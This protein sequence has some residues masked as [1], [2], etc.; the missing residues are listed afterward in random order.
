MATV[1]EKILEIKMKIEGA[2]SVKELKQVIEELTPEMASLDTT[3]EEY[4]QTV[5]LMV[6]AQEKLT[7]AMK[8]GKSQIDAQEGSYNALVNKMA[9]L[10]KVQKAVTDDESRQRLAV[11]INAIND[12]LKAYDQA[13]GVYVRNVGNYKSALEGFDGVVVSFGDR[14]KEAMDTLEPTKQKFE[15]VQKIA[16]GVASGFAALQGV[17]ALLGIENENLEKSLVKVQAA[18]AIAQGIGGL[19]DLYEGIARWGVAFSD[20]AKAAEN[21]SGVVETVN[22][23]TEAAA[24]ASNMAAAAS[25]ASASASAADATAKGTQAVATEGATIAQKGLNT[26][27]KANPIGIVITA[28]AALVG[29]FAWLKDDIV[30]LLGGTEKM[31][32]AWNNFSIVFSG[33]GNVIKQVALGPVKMLIAE[34]RTLVEVVSSV[35]QGDFKGAWEA[36]KKGF[37]DVVDA[38]KDTYNVIGNYQEAAA[39]KSAEIADKQRREEAEKRVKELE[40][41]IKDMEAKSDKDWKYSEEGKKAYEELYKRRAEMYKK[42]S[43]EYKQNQRDIWLYNKDYQ[44]RITKKEEEENKKRIEASKKAI[45]EVK[46]AREK[47][48]Q[49]YQTYVD[50]YLKSD[51]DKLLE[52]QEKRRKALKNAYDKG[53]IDY[54]TYV[55]QG[56][57]LLTKLGIEEQTFDFNIQLT[58]FEKKIKDV[59]A[60]VKNREFIFKTKVELDGET[61][62]VES[63]FGQ[64]GLDAATRYSEEFVDKVNKEIEGALEG[65]DYTRAL[66]AQAAHIITSY[67]NQ[68]EAVTEALR[69]AQ[70]RF[71]QFKEQYGEDNEL[72][73]KADKEVIKYFNERYNLE[74]EKFKKISDL[75]VSHLEKQIE[76][77]EKALEST[78]LIEDNKYTK[79][80]QTY[81]GLIDFEN[82][83]ITQTKL[84]RE[85]EKSISDARIATWKAEVEQYQKAATDMNITAEERVKAEEKKA[86][87]LARIKQEELQRDNIQTQLKIE[88]THNYINAIQDSLNGISDILGNVA[89]AWESSIQAQVDAGEISEEEGERQMEN[90]RGIQSAIALINTFSSA[91]SAYQ[92]LAPIPFV[93]PV[94]GAAAAAAAIA[95][96]LMQVKAINAVKKGDKG[97]EST[98]YAEVKPTIPNDYSPQMVQNATGGSEKEDLANALSQTNLWISV[99][100]IDSAQNRVKTRDKESSF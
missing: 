51:R 26:A 53:L 34:I 50:T 49:D 55:K 85:V 41:Y 78:I 18:M 17:T 27:M 5:D 37:E 48:L 58:D 70:Y 6:K 95:S 98:R 88:N 86:E 56:Q 7:T 94:L 52:E 47:A 66:E 38:A 90:M 81:N 80:M 59:E 76:D 23:A 99:K 57:E 91:V 54:E 61:K 31:N 25:A 33:V 9:A 87:I 20:T 84:L 42:D 36:I 97:G 40:D 19:K 16:T 35:A 62:G 60:F 64:L 63:Y 74:V 77:E 1:D 83:Y 71:D 22:N 21:M 10:K 72:T 75:R 12:Q 32:V 89:S 11:E 3:S 4:S 69:V 44:G 15:S 100:D 13:N 92:S 43:N 29:Y 67:D 24:N 45:E 96:G 82:N 65:I 73:Q 14:M 8:V 39:E 79:K 46:K 68:I 30:E 2:N 28:I 93:G